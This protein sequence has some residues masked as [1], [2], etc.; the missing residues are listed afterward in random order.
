M[1][2]QTAEPSREE[3]FAAW[4]AMND[5]LLDCEFLAGDVP[6][7]PADP[8][9]EDGLRVAEGDALR[10]FASI[11][12]VLAPENRAM[13]DKFIRFIGETFVRGLGAVWTSRP[14]VDDGQ[15][16]IGVRLPGQA[17]TL[18]IPTMLTSAVHRRT[19]D[20]WAFVFRNAR[21]DLDSAR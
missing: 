13:Y 21:E 15:P 11:D 14:M 1:P 3:G 12:D 6:G 4:L 17:E 16:Y 20:E 7:M 2:E 10:R 5:Y 18:E 9:S 19:G 8:Y